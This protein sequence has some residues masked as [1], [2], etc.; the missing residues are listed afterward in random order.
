MKGRIMKSRK[1]FTLVEL[2]VVIAII[3]ILAAMLLPALNRAKEKARQIS[4]ISNLKQC[5]GAMHQYCDDYNEFLPFMKK[6]TGTVYS[7]GYLAADNPSWYVRLAPYLNYVALQP[8]TDS[9]SYEFL[10]ESPTGGRKQGRLNGAYRCPSDDAVW[11]FSTFVVSGQYLAP[12]SYGYNKEM[13]NNEDNR[14]GDMFNTGT[15][16]LMKRNRLVQP[17]RRFGVGDAYSTPLYVDVWN[18]SST[19][20]ITADWKSFLRHSGQNNVAMLDGHCIGVGGG[21][22]RSSRSSVSGVKNSL[23]GSGDILP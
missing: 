22:L 1:N 5:I 7:S 2:L 3:A 8:G 15:F 11:K 12:V 9:R 19:N 10:V 17:S 4:C 18:L 21:Y 16:W 6:L 13:I 23:F 14:Y 20:F